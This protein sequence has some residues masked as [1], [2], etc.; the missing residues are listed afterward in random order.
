MVMDE[1]T[2]Y[3]PQQCS[4]FPLTFIRQ[5]VCSTHDAEVEV[6]FWYFFL[7]KRAGFDSCTKWVL[8]SRI[9]VEWFSD[10]DG[11][12]DLAVMAQIKLR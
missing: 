8:D 10:L 6:C 4:K 3:T 1:L 5:R 12:T 7:G 2:V 11:L 9:S